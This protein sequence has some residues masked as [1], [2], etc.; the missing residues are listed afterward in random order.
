ML[1]G[2]F[3]GCIFLAKAVLPYTDL[4]STNPEFLAHPHESPCRVSISG[5]AAASIYAATTDILIS[6]HMTDHKELPIQVELANLK[7]PRG[8][9]GNLEDHS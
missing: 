4:P 7:C 5:G 2:F 9:G 3:S 6:A 1:L 8:Q